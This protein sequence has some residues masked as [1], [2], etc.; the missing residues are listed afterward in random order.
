[1]SVSVRSLP[2]TSRKCAVD[3]FA[4]ARP[5][6]STQATLDSRRKYLS[7]KDKEGTEI[8]RYWVAAHENLI[9]SASVLF[10][11]M[12]LN[13]CTNTDINCLNQDTETDQVG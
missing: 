11:S 3:H 2:H 8:S 1:M 13:R 12:Y 9:C 6:C 5:L 7:R 4:R 10:T